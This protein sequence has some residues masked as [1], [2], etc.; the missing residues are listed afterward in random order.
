[1][2][3][4]RFTSFDIFIS[5]CTHQSCSLYYVLLV[6]DW[7]EVGKEALGTG[8]SFLWWVNEQG[9]GGVRQ[10]SRDNGRVGWV[11][12][13]AGPL[14][15][16]LF[17]VSFFFLGGVGGWTSG[18]GWVLV[19]GMKDK[20]CL[21]CWLSGYGWIFLIFLFLGNYLLRMFLLLISLVVYYLWFL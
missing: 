2:D 3:T 14:Q 21:E 9:Q 1:M 18:G 10:I 16:V 15:F 8:V 6:T 19:W 12:S 4:F 7:K 17:L 5:F 20:A 13:G 11:G